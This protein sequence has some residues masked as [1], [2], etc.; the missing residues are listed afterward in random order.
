MSIALIP[1]GE[2]RGGRYLMPVPALHPSQLHV[3]LVLEAQHVRLHL[4][5]RGMDLAL[6]LPE[7]GPTVAPTGRS[8]G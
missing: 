5:L 2:G 7:H 3:D 1:L 4:L 8:L 6:Q